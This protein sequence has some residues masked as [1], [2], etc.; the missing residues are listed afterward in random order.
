MFLGSCGSPWISSRG[1]DGVKCIVSPGGGG[2]VGSFGAYRGG[3]GV[4]GGLASIAAAGGVYGGLST[5]G[6][7]GS[8][9][10]ECNGS[11]V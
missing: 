5:C 9:V 11:A 10:G 7:F 3:L 2:G 8:G 4:G 1:P 6:G